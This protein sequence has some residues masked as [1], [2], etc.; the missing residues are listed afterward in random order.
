MWWLSLITLINRAGTMVIPFLSLYLTE[1][2][3]FSLSD[4]GWIMSAFGAGS[5]VGSFLGG[6]LTDRFGAYKTMAFSLLSS[7][8]LFIL[9]QFA[10]S[11]EAIAAMVFVV[12]LCADIFRP[13]L[14]VALKS[15][16]KPENQ[17][18]SVTL[19]RLAINLGFSV[20][21]AVGGFL[22]Y[23]FGYASLFWVD[24]I[25]C[26]SALFIFLYFLNPR[27]SVVQQSTA[28]TGTGSAYTDG[29]Y[30]LFCMGMLLFGFTFLQYFSTVPLYYAQSYGLTEAYIGLI[31]GF[32]GFLVFLVEM[33]LI[34]WLEKRGS[35]PTLMIIY[36][37]LLLALSFLVYNT[38]EHLSVLWVGIVLMSFAEMLVFPFS[39]DFA[40]NRAKRGAMG[41][42][43]ALYSIAF[44]IAHIL[45]HNTGLQL[46][47]KFSYSS[48]WTAMTFLCILGMLIFSLIKSI[49]K[50]A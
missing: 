29:L 49:R 46:I 36:G 38:V 6:K 9:T 37:F 33:P 39:N 18:R 34:Y 3:S 47:E 19:I 43:M 31:M 32:N 17:T 10:S 1:D 2:K 22:I 35:N 50:H 48:T 14:F 8:T 24:G 26:I 16:S 20:G 13:A 41:Q 12:I 5:V 40:M 25:T 23:N 11:F 42:Y 44:S 28:T 4:V 15:Y 21:P 27:R 30:L 45:G 7:G